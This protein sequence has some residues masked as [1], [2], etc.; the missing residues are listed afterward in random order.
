[1]VSWGNPKI[2]VVAGVCAALGVFALVP[3]AGNGTAATPVVRHVALGGNNGNPCTMSRPCASF[4]RAYQAAAPGDVVEVAGG[5]YPAQTLPADPAK[6]STAD[7]VFR[8]AAGASVSLAGF[9]SGN[10][11]TGVGAKHFE[12]RDLQIAGFVSIAWGTADV[13]LRNIDA[14][15]LK[16]TSTREVRV[17]GGD[18]GPWTDGI[19]HINA[20]GVPGCFPAEDIL[21]EGA[22]FHDF[23]I[24]D[25]DKHSECLMIW[26]GRRVT[27]RNSTF[28]NCTDFDVLV[29]P[30]NTSLVGSPADILFENNFL[31]AP[32]PGETATASCNPGCP[33]GGNAIAITD[34]SADPW[35]GAVIR[36][37]STL[38]GIRIDPAVANVVVKGNIAARSSA[39]A[40]RTSGVISHNVWSGVK[41]SP[42]DRLAALSDVFV[43][44]TA[45]DLRLT[46]TSQAIGAGDPDDHPARDIAGRLR[47]EAYAPDAGAWQREP[48]L[49]V[50]GRAIGTA[51]IG[52]TRTDVV[53]FYGPPRKRTRERL[54]DGSSV[55]VGHHRVRGGTLR[56]TLRDERVIAISTTSGYYRTLKG[57]GPTS[58]LRARANDS[59]ACRPVGAKIGKARL[60]VRPTHSKKPV[61]AELVV[62]AR[63]FVPSCAIVEK[64]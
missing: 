41:C 9:A 28:R 29:K 7:V 45:F 42:S 26:P 38:G 5:S 33:R 56:V 30:Y 55:E 64:P 54:V 46:A 6:T 53:E 63:G 31:D 58:P 37:N 24:T 20:C 36:Y 51:K 2:P 62:V 15:S 10:D 12:L 17:Y 35:S 23:T 11:K 16:L 60:Y 22:L 59:W 49:V 18:Y 43:D 4:A 57:L 21:I 48:A 44:A 14:G 34:G 19:S 52:M 27:I 13:T 61:V 25:P 47:P 1:M 40:C 8:P 32:M 50:A 39:F 3:P